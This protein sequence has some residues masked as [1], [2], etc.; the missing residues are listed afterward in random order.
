MKPRASQRFEPR[1]VARIGV[2]KIFFRGRPSSNRFRCDFCPGNC[3]G[4]T[5][6]AV[7]EVSQQIGLLRLS[8]VGVAGFE[9]AT[10]SS[11]T[12]CATKLQYAF[13]H[14]DNE[15]TFYNSPLFNCFGIASFA[16]FYI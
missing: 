9:P 11:R 13:A 3:P 10:P 2:G 8:L 14:Q 12:R 4:L 5:L 16:E 6:G 1:S 15:S 7:A